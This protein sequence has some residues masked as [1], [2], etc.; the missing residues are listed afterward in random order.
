M[1]TTTMT[2]N[3]HNTDPDDVVAGDAIEH[4]YEEEIRP[5]VAIVETAA[6]VTGRPVRE[7]P[8]LHDS[9]DAE[10]LDS[11]FE[12]RHRGS[13]ALEVT[14]QYAGLEFTLC[15]AGGNLEVRVTGIDE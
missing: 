12:T 3:P 4:C 7:L 13:G 1:A 2:D 5:S 6:A 15:H 14:F 11:L 8:V 9:V 10:A